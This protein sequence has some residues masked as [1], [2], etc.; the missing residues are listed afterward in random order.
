M[1]RTADFDFHLPP[2]NIAASPARPREAARL[3]VIPTPDT[4]NAPLPDKLPT[5]TVRDFPKFLRPGDLVVAND[6]EVIK[7]RLDT[8]RGHAKIG[9]TLDR[10]L[11]DGSWHALARNARRLHAGDQLTFSDDNVSAEI[12]SN[13]GDGGVVLRFSAEGAEFDAFLTRCGALALPPYIA[14]PFGPTAQDAVD[15]QTIFSREKGAVAAPT[16]G[17]H[18]TP[19]LL[20]AIDAAGAQR[21]TVTLHVGAGT[22]LPVR[23]DDLSQH[24]MHAEWGEVSMETAQRI[25][26]TRRRGGRVI[27]IGT[28]ALRLLE[29]ATAKD[30]TVAAWRGETSIFITPG[31]RFRAVDVL[32]TNFHLP[33]STLFML[34]SAFAGIE[35]MKRAY[36]QA[37]TEG[38]R[39]Y[40]Y[41]DACLIFRHKDS[42]YD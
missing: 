1:M 28:T 14:R 20:D 17:L 6:T 26:E 39:F 8:M 37:I 12:I 25:N 30:G 11:P 13:E 31:Y 21:C 33:K 7:A 23:S 22:F 9:I 32:L 41:G 42:R 10:I 38:F 29:S 4:A 27:A 24:V 15:Y 40:S 18:F 34:V 19:A 5:A 16:A 3:L 36:Q 35:T 2:E